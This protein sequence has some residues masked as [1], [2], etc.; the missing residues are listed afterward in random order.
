MSEAS[1]VARQPGTYEIHGLS[2]LP[3]L[4]KRPE[5]A[6]VRSL[7]FDLDGT[8]HDFRSAAR[9][10]MDAVYA[11]ICNSHPE[12]CR[13]DLERIYTTL[14]ERAEQNAF[15]ENK[16]SFQYRSERLTALLQEAGIDDRN[17]VE[18]LVRLYGEEFE[19][20]LVLAE[21]AEDVLRLLKR[22]YALHVVT[23]GPHDAQI[24]TL[25]RLGIG[26][27]FQEVFTSNCHGKRKE[28]GDLFMVVR[29]YLGLKG[30]D[31]VVIG[32]SSRDMLGAQRAGLSAIL[33][34]TQFHR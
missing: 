5:F 11:A 21:H 17:L 15:V 20:S 28:T 27:F 33:V 8:L 6:E 19:R 34:K 31:A 23:E 26:G 12:T 7:L 14:I 4:L 18:P 22:R 16:T 32:D 9:R 1:F 25:S 13:E 10:G 30:N 29:G 2:Q 24:R 3:E